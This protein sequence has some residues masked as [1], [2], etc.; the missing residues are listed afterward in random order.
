[1]VAD[2]VYFGDSKKESSENQGYTG[3]VKN[4][5]ELAVPANDFATIDGDDAQL[6]F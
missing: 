4:H 3:F 2:Q 6:P 5:P 1:M